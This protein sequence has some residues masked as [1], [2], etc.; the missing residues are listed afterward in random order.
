[1]VPIEGRSEQFIAFCAGI[2][3]Y[4][5]VHLYENEKE[6]MTEEELRKHCKN[7]GL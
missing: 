6:T 7:F 1:M 5:N 4:E 2:I 3:R